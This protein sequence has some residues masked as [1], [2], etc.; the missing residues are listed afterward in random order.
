MDADGTLMD[1]QMHDGAELCVR[2]YIWFFVRNLAG[3][4]VTLLAETCDTVR[5][6]KYWIE[7]KTGIPVH[8]QRLCFQGHVLEEERTLGDYNVKE[9]ST[10]NLLR[11]C[12]PWPVSQA[13]VTAGLIP[14]GDLD[15]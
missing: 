10:V 7:D 15:L 11:M 3:K 6:V 8:E 14:Y 2:Q 5:Q 12:E 13:G 4:A 1:F 9:E